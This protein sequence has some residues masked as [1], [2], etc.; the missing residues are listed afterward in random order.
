[1][2]IKSVSIRIEEEMLGS[3]ALWLIM[4]AVLSTAISWCRYG[5]ASKT[6]SGSTARS[7]AAY[8]RT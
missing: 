6:L 1:M 2:A 8:A 5:R 4:R 7:Q 3:W